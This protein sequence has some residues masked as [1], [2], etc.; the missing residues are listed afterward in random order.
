M[1]KRKYVVGIACVALAVGLSLNGCSKKE[2]ITETETSTTEADPNHTPYKEIDPE[3][4]TDPFMEETEYWTEAV[5]I[6]ERIEQEAADEKVTTEE[7][8]ESDKVDEAPAYVADDTGEQ[9]EISKSLDGGG[10]IAIQKE[11]E[12]T[13]YNNMTDETEVG[14][15]LRFDNYDSLEINPVALTDGFTYSIENGRLKGVYSDGKTVEVIKVGT[16]FV[17]A[18]KLN[19]STVKS[20][21]SK[22]FNF[23]ASG[24]DSKKYDI[25]NN[26]PQI[27]GEASS[28][29]M[30][31]SI[32]V[33]RGN[34]G[35]YAIKYT[36]VLPYDYIEM[37]SNVL[38]S[39]MN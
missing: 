14:K 31:S 10:A 15:I 1:R 12:F 27:V 8:D 17:D 24:G 21:A 9:I 4:V 23:D 38:M 11:E 5:D 36:G 37:E 35:V 20:L 2:D 32:V 16:G 6:D 7:D 30:K 29:D 34:N 19:M 13:K 28:S 25:N 39:T 26:G 33:V 18:S 3:E 22:Y